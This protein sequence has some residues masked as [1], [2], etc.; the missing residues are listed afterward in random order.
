MFMVN[1]QQNQAILFRF[2]I[3]TDTINDQLYY[4]LNIIHLK[5]F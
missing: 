4:S 5:V 2:T 3:Y 1:Y